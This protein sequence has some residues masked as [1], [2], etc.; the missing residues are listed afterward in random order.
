MANDGGVGAEPFLPKLMA[1]HD[2][3]RCTW[4]VIFVSNRASQARLHSQPGVIAARHGLSV[5]DLPLI[6]DYRVHSIDRSESKE[7]TKWT[8]R[9]LRL[10]PH[11]F[12]DFVAKQRKRA[13]ARWPGDVRRSTHAT[14][15]ERQPGVPGKQHQSLRLGDWQGLEQHGIHHTE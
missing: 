6:A 1:E 3:R 5:N 4:L 13:R 10:L 9:R 7:I 11:P 8:F 14:N 2:H 12:K 15:S